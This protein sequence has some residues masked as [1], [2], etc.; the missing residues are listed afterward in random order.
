MLPLGACRQAGGAAGLLRASGG[1]ARGHAQV[2][3]VRHTCPRHGQ[4]GA[5]P[6]ASLTEQNER[7]FWS[8]LFATC[9]PESFGTLFRLPS[10]LAGTL[11]VA[12]ICAL[13][14][15]RQGRGHRVLPIADAPALRRRNRWACAPP[16]ALASQPPCPCPCAPVPPR[17]DI[18]FCFGGKGSVEEVYA[19]CER[20][21]GQWGIDA[22]AQMSE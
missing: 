17:A 3:A 4:A 14:L 13:L 1:A 21:G 11:T 5:C 2:H 12:P 16:D 10:R 19:E 20:S 9:A 7:L 8:R 15:C 6:A 18:D 22:I